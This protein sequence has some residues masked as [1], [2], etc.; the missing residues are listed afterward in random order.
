M[1]VVQKAGEEQEE[2]EAEGVRGEEEG[3]HEEHDGRSCF[4]SLSFLAEAKDKL[5]ADGVSTGT[6]STALYSVV[7]NCIV[8]CY[9]LRSRYDNMCISTVS[10]KQSG[11][12]HADI[13]QQPPSKEKRVSV[14]AHI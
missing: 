12:K 6:D 7:L 1:E 11:G 8:L 3:G 13:K 14:H 10:V 5:G 4:Y 9:V 2:E